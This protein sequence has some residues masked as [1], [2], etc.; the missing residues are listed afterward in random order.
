M[1][2]RSRVRAAIP[3]SMRP[4]TKRAYGIFTSL[5]APLRIEP[6]FMVVGGQRCGTT[7]IFKALSEHPQILRPIVEKGTDYYTLY[8]DRG[9]AWYRGQY[10]LRGSASRRTGSFGPPAAFEACTYYLF[11]PFAMERIARDYPNLKLVAMLRDPVERAYS[12]YKHEYARGFDTEPN[13]MRALELEDER[14]AGEVDKM[15]VDPTYE[16]FSH[17]HH[18]YRRR[19]QFAEQLDRVFQFFSRE[20]VHIMD[21][22]AFFADPA[23]EYGQLVEFLGLG[24]RQPGRIMRHNGRPSSP[25]PADARSFLSSHY[26]EHDARLADLLGRQ[27][28]WLHV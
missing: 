18:A 6:S 26:R 17:R 2:F 23:G 12:A 20:Q 8:S 9:M 24:D 25:M 22:E 14:L 13:F 28:H 7:T 10:P 27:P 11:H 4:A 5:S 15:A 21:S 16:S 3:P 19:G 1:S